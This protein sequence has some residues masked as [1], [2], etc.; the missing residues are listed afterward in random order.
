MLPPAFLVC[1]L[2]AVAHASPHHAH[3]VFESI[4]SPDGWANLGAAPID[5]IIPLRIALP[6]A[7]FAALEEHLYAVSDPAHERY[8]AHLSKS[9]VEALVAPHPDSVSAVDAWLL[10]HGIPDSACTRSPAGDW[11]SVRVPVPV[12]ERMLDTTFHVWKHTEDGNEIVRTTRYSLPAHL[13]AHVELVQPTTLFSRVKARRAEAR[14]VGVQARVHDVRG[15]VA[16][17]RSDGT[18]LTVD[19][20]CNE[21]V[22]IA[23]IRQFF[24]IG[25]YRASGTNGNQIAVAGYSE[26]Y[27]NAKDQQLFY[28]DQLPEA[29]NTTFKYVLVNGGKNGQDYDSDTY[30]EN[31]D[32]QTVLG[33][34]F[35]ATGT[36]YSTGGEGPWIE[37][38]DTRTDTIAPYGAWLDF[39]LAQE[40][41]PQ[42][43]STGYESHEQTIP[44]SYA[45]RVCAG[46][47]QLGARGTSL[48][49]MSGNGGVGDAEGD[50]R[51]Q[52][53]WT[54]DG[55]HKR[56]FLPSFP[57]SCPFVTAVG[58]TVFIPEVAAYSSGGG[59]SNYWSRPSY[60]GRAV[61]EYLT[62]QLRGT[63]AGLYNPNGRAYPD[64]A[65]Q[66]INFRV[67]LYG[68]LTAAGGGQQATAAFAGLVSLLNDA[69]LAHGKPPLGF[70][71][72][73]LYSSGLAVF[74]DI[75]SGN[76]PGCGTQ[77]FNATEGWDPITGLGTPDFGK[78]KDLAL[79]F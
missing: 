5:H 46:F 63:Y 33:L 38:S 40:K 58:S 6:Q 37:D 69:R 55:R 15:V 36:Y 20:G 17:A 75:T 31:S 21:T 62:T 1:A 7:N 60:Q 72:P 16:V 50:P 73:F 12:A 27:A 2:A 53:C 9:E 66:S 52:S 56:Q 26:E 54:N 48:L 64:V 23:C 59:F 22:T 14:S 24:N 47:A 49:V 71:N 77:G 4:A 76:A 8:G 70:L 68:Q 42:T 3:K 43:I 29:L 61:S 34:A 74:N 18:K 39:A 57:A 45:K 79:A 35:P 41:L 32:M 10:E 25:D 19:A 51:T 30:A 44:E 11:V 65:A 78:L 67:A 28:A 13:H